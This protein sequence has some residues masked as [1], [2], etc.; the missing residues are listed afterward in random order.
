MDY[1]KLGAGIIALGVIFILCSGLYYL[2]NLDGNVRVRSLGDA[3]NAW[4]NSFVKQ[5]NREKA[6]NYMFKS[7]IVI[8][9][10]IVVYQ[11]SRKQNN[12]NLK[13]VSTNKT[14]NGPR[15]KINQNY[16]QQNFHDNTKHNVSSF[17]EN[18]NDES[19]FINCYLC[20]KQISKSIAVNYFNSMFI[21]KECS[22]KDKVE[23]EESSLLTSKN[24]DESSF[25]NCDLCAK[26]IP[27]ESAIKYLDSMFICKTCSNNYSK[28]KESTSDKISIENSNNDNSKIDNRPKCKNCNSILVKKKTKKDNKIVL[29]C[30]NYPD[31]KYLIYI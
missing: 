18:E 3:M 15:A 1:Q 11:A 7:L 9:V 23:Q 8:A 17:S 5:H 28:K 13:V 6:L 26:L 19:I 12:Q 2:S 16:D 20:D 30:P 24:N 21:C 22:N 4:S 10:G 31:C 14:S 25:I 27:T 29:V